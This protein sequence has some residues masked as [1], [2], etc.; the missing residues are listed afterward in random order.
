MRSIQYPAIQ[1]SRAVTPDTESALA[2]LIVRRIRAEWRASAIA[3]E[4]RSH[5]RCR[6]DI[7]ARL[8]DS[9]GPDVFIGVEV[10]LANWTRAVRQAMLNQYAV[11][12]SLIAMP[13]HRVSD[14][15]VQV[16]SE[17]GVGVLSVDACQLLI[18]LPAALGSPDVILLQ[19]MAAQLEPMKARGRLRVDQLVTRR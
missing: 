7:C 14:H 18:T 5:G 9:H 6:I 3:T 4:V 16:A 15:V 1:S 12:A 17:Q 2:E 8:R 11:D 13:I 10:K 19:R